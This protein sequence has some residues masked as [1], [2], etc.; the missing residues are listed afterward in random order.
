MSGIAGV[1]GTGPLEKLCA[2]ALAM[3]RAE[4]HRG[5]DDEGLIALITSEPVCQAIHSRLPLAVDHRFTLRRQ[6][7]HAE[8]RGHGMGSF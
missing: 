6:P 2:A 4:A 5:P 7:A 3:L 1:L 8:R